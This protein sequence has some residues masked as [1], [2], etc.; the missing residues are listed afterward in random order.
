MK[1]SLIPLQGTKLDEKVDR[2]S[3]TVLLPALNEECAIGKVIDEVT[4]CSL[5]SMGYSTTLLVVDGHSTDNTIDVARSKGADVLLQEGKGKGAAVRKALK[6]DKSEYLVMMDA[7][8]TYPADCILSLLQELRSGADVVIGSRI[9][10]HIH[11]GAM[12]RVNYIGNR[13]LSCLASALYLKWITDLCSGMWALGPKARA[14]LVLNSD[15]FEIE[16]E[17]FAQASKANLKISEV[18]IDYRR[19]IGK[20]K[21]GGVIDGVSIASKLLRKRLVG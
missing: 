15:R 20:E 8:Y 2:F 10:G 5:N 6:Y 12:P 9:T 7:D 11:P 18:P 1:H 19:R 14:Q 17:M 21:L 4:F 13:L 16:A 3:L